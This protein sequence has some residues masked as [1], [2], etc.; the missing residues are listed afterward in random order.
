MTTVAIP[1]AY[2]VNGGYVPHAA[3]AGVRNVLGFA[4]AL[5]PLTGTMLAIAAM[6][7]SL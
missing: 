4:F 6:L 1:K 3:V 7:L 2:V 5:W